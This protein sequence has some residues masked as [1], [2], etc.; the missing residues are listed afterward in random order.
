MAQSISVTGWAP[1]GEPRAFTQ[2]TA[3]LSLQLSESPNATWQA[4]FRQVADRIDTPLGLEG[5]RIEVQCPVAHVEIV[6][7][8]VK[9]RLVPQINHLAAQVETDKATKRQ[10]AADQYADAHAAIS[11][12]VAKIKFD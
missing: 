1:G 8:R 12:Q 3:A 5:D 7:N 6:V 9:D 2:L 10:A 11:A 4:V